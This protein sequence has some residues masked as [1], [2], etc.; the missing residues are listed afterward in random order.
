MPKRLLLAALAVLLLVGGTAPVMAAYQQPTASQIQ[1]MVSLIRFLKARLA[2]DGAFSSLDHDQ[3]FM[4]LVEAVK[5][6]GVQ[7]VPNVRLSATMSE[8]QLA[9]A[10]LGGTSEKARID[11]V[12]DI[13]NYLGNSKPAAVSSYYQGAPRSVAP[14]SAARPSAPGA[15]NP[16]ASAEA[17]AVAARSMQKI[18]QARAK[19]AA[20]QARQAKLKFQGQKLKRQKQVIEECKLALGNARKMA[21]E[22]SDAYWRQWTNN[23]LRQ[24]GIDTKSLQ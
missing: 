18:K 19:M 3:R 22:K 1:Q 4:A 16:Q 15:A 20:I 6:F 14:R 13:G 23:F 8:A 5:L 10:F 9:S 11:L 21:P 2:Q 17:R 24:R 7:P 12:D